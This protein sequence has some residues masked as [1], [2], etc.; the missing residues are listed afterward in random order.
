VW[1]KSGALHDKARVFTLVIDG[2]AKAYALEALNAAG[3]VLNDEFAGR[4]VL[5]HY[6]DAVGRVRLPKRWGTEYANDLTLEAARAAIRGHRGLLRELTAEMLLAMPTATR[7][8]LLEE[9][10]LDE[11]SGPLT[12]EISID[13]E[14]RNEV[15]SRGLIG[16]TRAYERG[17]HRFEGQTRDALLDER[18]RAWKVT[19]E[20]LVGPAGERLARL[21]GELAYWF[22]WFAFFP[23]TVV[24]GAAR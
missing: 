22:G 3:G 4:R 16:E 13:A 21:P 15:A 17:A 11:R 20:A 5:V 10:T 18:G 2:R 6:R 19:E 7:L 9:F 1:Q 24:Y 8:T 23:Q 14:L 12:P